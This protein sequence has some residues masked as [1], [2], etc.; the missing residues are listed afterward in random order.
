ATVPNLASGPNMTV[1]Y[2]ISPGTKL[3]KWKL[4]TKVS[5]SQRVPL[6]K[7]LG[8]ERPCYPLLTIEV[9]V[10]VMKVEVA[11]MKVEVGVA[12]KTQLSTW[13]ICGGY[14]RLG[15]ALLHPQGKIYLTS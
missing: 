5:S 14:N 6:I 8:E 11:V 1:D 10:A 3:E 12:F 15:L 4:M 7:K 2:N 13:N 9:E